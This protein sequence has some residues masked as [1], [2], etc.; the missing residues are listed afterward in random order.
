MPAPHWLSSVQMVAVQAITIVS[1]HGVRWR[2]GI[3]RDHL[4]CGRLEPH[5]EAELWVTAWVHAPG[6]A[7]ALLMHLSTRWADRMARLAFLTKCR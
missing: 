7:S 5:R 4:C 2:T 6:A 3:P 1:E